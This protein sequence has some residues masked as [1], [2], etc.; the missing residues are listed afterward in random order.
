MA[1]AVSLGTGTVTDHGLCWGPSGGSR[2]RCRVAR[3]ATAEGQTTEWKSTALRA[4]SGAPSR[5]IR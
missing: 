4:Y 5:P 1:R 2:S 3:L